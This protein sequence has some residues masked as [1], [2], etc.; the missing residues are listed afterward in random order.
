MDRNF[1][2]SLKL[3]LKYEGGYVNHP[4][5]PGGPTNKGITL[6][7][8]QRYINRSGTIANLKAITDQ[9][10]AKVYRKQYWDAVKGDDLPD[11]VDFA[12]F[13]FGVNSGPARAAKY[14]QAVVG[15]KADGQIGPA[16]IAAVK[17]KPRQAVISDLCAKRLTF[18]KGLKTWPTFRK[19]WESRVNSVRAEALLMQP[20]DKTALTME[21]SPDAIVVTP[22][23]DEAQTSTVMVATTT[24][25]AAPNVAPKPSKTSGIVTIL[26]MIAGAIAAYFG[27]G[28]PQ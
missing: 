28:S 8:Y 2:K 19:G 20:D 1:A 23:N 11:G 16:T 15:A 10:V 6:A 18:L 17:S 25:T 9:E 21:L 5:D 26:A 3:V 13:D 12:T 14:L 27:W 4:K 22:N 7:T 24:E